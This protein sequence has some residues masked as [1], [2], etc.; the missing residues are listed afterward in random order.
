VLDGAFSIGVLHH[1]PDP[2]GGFEAMARSTR[3]GGSL[4]V[5]VYPKRGFY[6]FPTVTLY[7]RVFRL[8][9]PACGYYP[10]L[11]Y[12]HFAVALIRPLSHIPVLGPMLRVAVPFAAIPDRRWALLDT[13][14]ALTPSYQSTHEPYEVF[15]W[16][17]SCGLIDI[18]PS[19]WSPTAWHGRNPRN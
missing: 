7:R 6:D 1:T 17:K 18:E 2:K 9:A 3:P 4:A 10:A 12:S 15:T 14:D 8:L 16:L 5:S 11:L 13:F 19:R